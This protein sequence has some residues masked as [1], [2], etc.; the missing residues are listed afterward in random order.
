MT[1]SVLMDPQQV[2]NNDA[3]F[4]LRSRGLDIKSA[5]EVLLNGFVNDIIEQVKNKD[6]KYML[7]KNIKIWLNE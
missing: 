7:E 4:Y 1:L 2:T 3:I 6:I 5:K